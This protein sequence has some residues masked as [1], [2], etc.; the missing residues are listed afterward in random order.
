MQKKNYTETHLLF[1]DQRHQK[2]V[3]KLIEFLLRRKFVFVIG[4]AI[5][6]DFKLVYSITAAITSYT[7]IFIQ[8]DYVN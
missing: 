3:A 8:M 5:Q 2:G 6:V 7:I 4:G 1:S